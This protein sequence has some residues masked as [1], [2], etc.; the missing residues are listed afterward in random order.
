MITAVH[1]I[2][3][4]ELGGAQEN[5][6]TTC[7]GLDR[8]RFRVSLW[9]GSGGILD[10]E[11]AQIPELD[12]QLLPSLVRPVRPG[13]DARCLA[14]LVVRLK[15]AR[16][17]HQAAGHD[18]RAFIVHTHS[19]KA[20]ILGRAAAR[21]AGVPIIVHSIHGFG[22]H[23]GQ[24][25]AKHALFV[26]AERAAARLTDAFIS[27]SRA[28]LD[29]ALSRHIV[30]PDQR[31]LVIRSGFDLE[32]FLAETAGGPGLRRELGL[33]PEDEVLVSVA[34]L[35]PQKD[36]LTLVAAMAILHQRRPGAVMLYAGDGEL[37]G[38][39]EAEIT[40]RG[41]GSCFRLLGWRRDIPALIAAGD[42]VVLS[43]IYE[44][45]PRS[46]VQAVLA[47]RPFVGTRV[48]G[49]PE[50][51]RHGKNGYLVDPEDPEALAGAMEQALRVHPVD[52]EDRVRVRAWDAKTMVQEQEQL[53]EELVRSR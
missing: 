45:L 6:L 24:H 7:A 9:S 38:V 19:S 32:A 5:T 27:V 47:E 22:F 39:V 29:E 2:T 23:P 35:K 16:R 11:A 34:N 3:Q 15:K 42:V 12:R 46:A 50:I 14:E 21:A 28:S 40:R 31:S 33:G 26:E 10:A 53:Y 17:A 36:P 48:D 4:L 44:G 41:L 20:G 49:T 8:R 13:R 25:P 51:I 1:V 52:P 30:R 37:R 18:P 43:S